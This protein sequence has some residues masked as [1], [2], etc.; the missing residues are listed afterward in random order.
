[1]SPTGAETTC[2][3]KENNVKED[4]AQAIEQI[5]LHKGKLITASAGVREHAARVLQEL[6]I[7]DP[8]EAFLVGDCDAMIYDLACMLGFARTWSSYKKRHQMLVEIFHASGPK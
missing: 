3:R 4:I 7:K 1:M 8:V 2:A 6:G 5:A